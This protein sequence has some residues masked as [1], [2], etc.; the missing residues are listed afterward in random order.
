MQ[1]YSYKTKVIREETIQG[2][3]HREI[4]P[5]VNVIF[6]RGSLVSPPVWVILD[7]GAS[8]SRLSTDLSNLLYPNGYTETSDTCEVETGT[9]TTKRFR[10]K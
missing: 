5:F 1:R 8:T 4:V 2:V 7:S 6:V 10:K 9:G 3:L